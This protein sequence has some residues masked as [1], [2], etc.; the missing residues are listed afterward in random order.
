MRV[1]ELSEL[2]YL[3]KKMYKTYFKLY[4]WKIVGAQMFYSHLPYA[5]VRHSPHC[6]AQSSIPI[7]PFHG[8]LSRTSFFGPYKSQ[9]R[10]K[11]RAFRWCSVSFLLCKKFR[12]VY[13]KLFSSFQRDFKKCVVYVFYTY[14]NLIYITYIYLSQYVENGNYYCEYNLLLS[15]DIKKF[16][17]HFSHSIQIL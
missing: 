12:I 13:K 1:L 5:S 17:A 7:P 14:R 3:G 11:N 10:D 15:L 16:R 8:E 2:L 4:F 6:W 9:K